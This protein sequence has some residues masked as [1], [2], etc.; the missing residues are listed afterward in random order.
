MAEKTTGKAG[1]EARAAALSKERMKEIASIAAAKRWGYKA[2]HKGNFKE[3][4]GMDVECYVLNDATKT[5][6]I[7]QIGMG[8]A[9]GLSSRGNALPRFLESKGMQECLGAELSEKLKNPLIFQWLNSGARQ[10]PNTPIHTWPS[11]ENP[12][13]ARHN[14]C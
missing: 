3:E 5:A 12:A 1:G 6:V 4:F 2:I 7:S 13:S 9:I 11:W 14:S 10:Q 8:R